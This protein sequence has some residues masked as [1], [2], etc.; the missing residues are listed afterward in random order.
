MTTRQRRVRRQRTL[1][2]RTLPIAVRLALMLAGVLLISGVITD[3]VLRQVIRDGQTQVLFDDL[4]DVSRTNALSVVDVMGQEIIAMSEFAESSAVSRRLTTLNTAGPADQPA[5]EREVFAIDEALNLQLE[6]FGA[7][8]PE[9]TSVAIVGSD[10]LVRAITEV[11]PADFVIDRSQWAWYDG[12]LAVGSTGTYIAGPGENFLTDQQGVGLAIPVIASSGEPLGVLYALWDMSNVF[13]VAQFG[14]SRET[15]VIEG[16]GT[17]LAGAGIPQGDS[18]PLA[19]LGALQQSGTQYSYNASDGIPWIGT[20]T[21]FSDL[22]LGD[23]SIGELDWLVTT[24]QPADALAE[25]TRILANRV[26]I[27]LGSS[28]VLVTLIIGLFMTQLLRPLRQ[29]TSA[30]AAIER[31]NLEQPIPDLPRDELG[32]LADTLRGLVSRLVERLEELRAAVQVSQGT[33]LTQNIPEMLQDVTT[34]LGAQFR[35]PDVRAY[36]VDSGGRR[37]TITAAHG[38]EGERLLRSGHS[39]AV[40]ETTLVGRALLLGASQIGAERQALREAGLMTG[41]A[42]LAMPLMSGNQKLGVLHVLARRMG[43]F[44]EQEVD[45]VR[46]IADQAAASITNARLLE[47]S[48]TSLREIETLNRR[49]TR[50]A[51]DEYL[52]EEGHIRRTLDPREAYPS[53]LEVVRSG[54]SIQAHTYEEDGR[55]ILAAPLILRGEP[56]GSLAI[57]R[58]SGEIWTRDEAQLVESVAAR[59]TL[60]AEG[61][62][63]VEETSLRAHREQQA[64]IVSAQLLSRATSVDSVLRS[65]LSELSDALGSDR[66]SLRL[67]GAP[68]QSIVPDDDG[69]E[70]G[71]NGDRNLS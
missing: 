65:A 2:I 19:L 20:Y 48:A 7:G 12:A 21:T 15:L 34:A 16:D 71:S 46:L 5:V 4:G 66:V 69:D 31:G 49:L 47:Q 33:S 1:N 41:A 29:L 43:E 50:E 18:I 9:F 52:G 35:Y 39:V 70:P 64:N 13:A 55:S 62:R 54:E 30:A 36:L 25:Q 27:A 37:A 17:V 44:E 51:W 22:M 42:E 28:V 24:R 40:D 58:P 8:H 11:P 38:G 68:E 67:A 23:M 56:V 10:G 60:I 32:R 61:I 45:I 59:M 26:R 63:L 57:S 53:S 14:G 3:L 6:L